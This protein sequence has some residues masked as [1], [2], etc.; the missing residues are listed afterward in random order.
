[1]RPVKLK[2]AHEVCTDLGINRRTLRR[3]IGGGRDQE[4]QTK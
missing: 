4:E 3:R 2:N 1:M